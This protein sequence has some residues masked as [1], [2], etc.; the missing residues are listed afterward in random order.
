MGKAKHVS[1]RIVNHRGRSLALAVCQT[2]GCLVMK[3]CCFW[4][5]S[6]RLASL[7]L[8][9]MRRIKNTKAENTNLFL[10]RSSFPVD[11]CF[12]TT[13]PYLV[14]GNNKTQVLNCF[15]FQVLIMNQS[16]AC[17]SHHLHSAITCLKRLIK[18]H[19]ILCIKR[20]PFFGDHA[21]ALPRMHCSNAK[22]C[23]TRY[24]L[25]WYHIWGNGILISYVVGVP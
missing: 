21:F 1:V 13:K 12:F 15:K 16:K 2:F 10:Q 20:P 19:C 3:I 18:K 23:L 24:F 22:G 7:F 17:L 25:T 6:S 8:R 5:H 14:Y 9:Q 4:Q 11:F